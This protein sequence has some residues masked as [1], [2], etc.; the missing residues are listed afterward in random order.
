MK[1]STS[2]MTNQVKEP[3]LKNGSPGSRTFSGIRRLIP[4]GSTL[5]EAATE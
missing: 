5:I 1:A 2:A 3:S 4:N